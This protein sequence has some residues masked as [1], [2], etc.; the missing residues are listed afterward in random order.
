MGAPPP[1]FPT[2]W[3]RHCTYKDDRP[4]Y[5]P[6]DGSGLDTVVDGFSLTPNVWGSIPVF[7]CLYVGVQIVG[8]C[9][10]VYVF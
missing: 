10:Y 3:I 4:Q 5:R 2:S 1:P 8:V 7:V 6:L 9:V